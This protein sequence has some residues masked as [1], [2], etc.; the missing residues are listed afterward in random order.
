MSENQKQTNS[1][2]FMNHFS[3]SDWYVPI[4]AF[5]TLELDFDIPGTDIYFNARLPFNSKLPIIIDTDAF[6][7]L[8]DPLNKELQN[9]IN[10]TMHQIQQELQ[11]DL[12]VQLATL[13]NRLDLTPNDY[14]PPTHQAYITESNDTAKEYVSNQHNKSKVVL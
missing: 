4:I 9:S 11:Q 3:Q 13:W 8:I 12:H 2:Y 14:H 7:A 5:P 1:F 10:Q 6:E